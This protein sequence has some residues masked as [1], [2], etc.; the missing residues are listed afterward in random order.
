MRRRKWQRNS[1][2]KTPLKRTTQETEFLP[3]KANEVIWPLWAL[4]YMWYIYVDVHT[5][6]K[7][8]NLCYLKQ[9]GSEKIKT[10]ISEEPSIANY[11]LARGLAHDP[12]V[13][14]KSNLEGN[15]NGVWLAVHRAALP[16]T[17]T[18]QSI[19]LLT[20]QFSSSG[21]LK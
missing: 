5:K 12:Q 18:Q 17:P 9:G 16:E 10:R 11:V 1:L 20:A 4:A 14:A 3:S 21:F 19:A 13:F 6:S 15:P 7:W 2:I 8:I